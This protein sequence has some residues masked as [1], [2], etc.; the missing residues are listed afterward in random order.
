LNSSLIQ[1]QSRKNRLKKRQAR[2]G[3]A[4]QAIQPDKT[5]APKSQCAPM[6]LAGSSAASWAACGAI[7]SMTFAFWCFWLPLTYGYP[8]LSVEAVCRRQI[9]GYRL[10][11]A[12]D[13]SVH[14][15]FIVCTRRDRTGKRAKFKQ[16]WD[17][18]KVNPKRHQSAF[19]RETRAAWHVFSI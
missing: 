8:G 1:S 4:G 3:A 6:Q 14:T 11:F 9:L 2:K 12:Y 15:V 7:L 10:H 17:T 13:Y 5:P 18:S 16:N 19:M